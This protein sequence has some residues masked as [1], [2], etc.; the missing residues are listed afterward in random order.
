[1]AWADTNRLVGLTKKRI[2]GVLTAHNEQQ[3]FLRHHTLVSR[4]F[5]ASQSSGTGEVPVWEE[6]EMGEASIDCNIAD[7]HY[8]AGWRTTEFYVTVFMAMTPIMAG[9][10]HTEFS[11]EQVQGW[12][13]LAAGIASAG[14]AVARSSSKKA[15]INAKVQ[16]HVTACAP[17]TA[18]A[19]PTTTTTP[20]SEAS[21]MLT[22]STAIA[23]SLTGQQMAAVPIETLA[24]I[25][26][27]LD[28]LAQQA[29]AMPSAMR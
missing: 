21:V 18:G 16:A 8:K 10:F 6:P 23:G 20:N 2:V 24:V 5:D 13:A 7:L 11:G 27:R 29:N 19:S 12:A 1:M 26:T 3:Q 17:T 14:Y 25:L 28:Q 4:L 22:P 15:A 9:L